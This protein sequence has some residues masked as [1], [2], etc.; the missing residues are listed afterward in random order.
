MR[1]VP[2]KDKKAVMADMKRIYQA[3]SEQQGYERLLEF[4]EK[5]NRKYSLS[6]KSWLDNWVNVSAFFKY[7]H[8]IRRF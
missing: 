6:C 7:D 8:G 1:Y 4:E 3:N 5:R 2:E